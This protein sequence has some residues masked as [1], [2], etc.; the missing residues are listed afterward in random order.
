VRFDSGDTRG[1]KL[2]EARR[3]VTEDAEWRNRVREC[4]YRP[5]DVRSVYWT[6]W[7]IDWPRSEVM[8]HLEPGDNLALIARRQM[9]PGEP[10]SYFWVTRRIALDGVIRS[11]N[12]GSESLF[13]L[14]LNDESAEAGRRVNLADGFLAQLAA[15]IQLDFAGA[16]RGD[17]T[18]SFGAEDVG[19]FIYALFS[20]PSYRIRYAELLPTDFPR[21]FLPGDAELFRRFCETGR[22]LVALHTM[23]EP[24]AGS[25]VEF[26]HDRDDPSAATIAAG[27]PKYADRR[28]PINRHVG[29][30]P[31][32]PEVWNFRAGGHQ[33]CRKWLKD[34]RGR[35]LTGEDIAAYCRIVA[36]IAET[37]SLT[38]SLDAA[39]AEFGGWP[40]AFAL[41]PSKLPQ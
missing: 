3:R 13:P 15:S 27:Y 19:D 17:L 37:L 23:T 35:T 2:A 25:D 11:D 5:F 40:S 1:W 32:S 33:A 20:T 12:R 29:F 28:V 9:P 31:V 14:Y 38:Q 21:V 34:R 41:G 30:S 16:R 36:A 8:R 6:E 7:M 39:I 22:R 26:A 10:C 18:N 24:P 4:L